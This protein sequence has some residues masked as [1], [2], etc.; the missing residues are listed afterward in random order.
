LPLS[1][2]HKKGGQTEKHINILILFIIVFIFITLFLFSTLLLAG[3]LKSSKHSAANP[4]ITFTITNTQSLPTIIGMQQ[5]ILLNVSSS[6]FAGK[7]A[8][9]LGNLRFYSGANELYS[10]CEANCSSSAS[11]DSIFWIRLPFSIGASSSKNINV[12]FLPKNTEYDGVYAG[13]SPQQSNSYAKY[14][15]GANVFPFLYQNFVGTNVPSG[16]IE[17]G[18]TINNGV[19]TTGTYAYIIT[20]ATYGL[21]SSQ[22]LDLKGNI[23]SSGLYSGQSGYI[24]SKGDTG[25]NPTLTASI[26]NASV[27]GGNYFAHGEQTRDTGNICMRASTTSDNIFSIYYPNSSISKIMTNYSNTIILNSGLPSSKISIGTWTRFS[28]IKTY[29]TWIRL[30]TYPPNGVMPTISFSS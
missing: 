26:T 3:T 28:Y 5:E 19:I 29:I 10:W 21:N 4:P 11:G 14:D 13:E 16:W 22:I 2:Y 12:T 15:N 18:S 1:N 20:S 6:Q 25:I 17:N 23:T 7:V 8:P 27:C 30:R 9:D 24:T